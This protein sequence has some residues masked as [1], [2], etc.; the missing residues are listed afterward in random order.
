MD[1]AITIT[2][3]RQDKRVAYIH[4]PLQKGEAELV[5]DALRVVERE[6]IQMALTDARTHTHKT[7]QDNEK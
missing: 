5:L 3:D 2:I 6:V 7:E 1:I 4:S